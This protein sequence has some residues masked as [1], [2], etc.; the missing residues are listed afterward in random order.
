MTIVERGI[1]ECQ[2]GFEVLI[3]A[4]VHAEQGTFQPQFITVERM[5]AILTSQQLPNGLDYPNLPFPELQRITVP[6]VYSRGTFLVYV[7]DI[8]LL[9][10]TIFYL[11]KVLPYPI[12]RQDVFVFIYSLKEYIFVDSL[13]KQ[14]GKI[15]ANELTRCFQPNALQS[16]CKADIPIFSYLPN[17]DCEMTL[18][19]PSSTQIPKSCDVRVTKLER[20]YWI[21]LHMCNQWLYVAPKPEK[22]SAL[23]NENV[24][25]IDLRGRG[26]LTL[27]PGCKAY[28]SYVTLYAMSTT[29]K[30]ISNDFLPTIPMNFDCCVIFGKT[31]E[32]SQVPLPIPLSNVL[33]SADDL[34]MASHKVS[35]VER[36]IQEQEARDYSQYYKH[37]ATWSGVMSV[38][39]FFIV[40]C[41]CCC[42]CCKWYRALWF[43]VWDRWT[44]KQCWKETTERLCINITNVQGKQ[45]SV[46]YHATKTSPTTSLQHLPNLP[47]GAPEDEEPGEV[48][49]PSPAPQRRSSRTRKGFR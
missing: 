14:Y 42:C 40:S 31:K 8:P 26:R 32:F 36:M 17:D 18:I 3:D 11:H 5:R 39:I 21:P 47:I 27:Q 38:I 44:P 46:R 30:N 28:T 23:C 10:S 4:L 45:P 22:L 6:H 9:S 29:V 19:H 35:E 1:M 16:I 37:I 48:Y 20:T 49:E 25:Q 34:R 2:H 24:R 43:K 7:L 13:K 41:C 33:S 15:S 12:P